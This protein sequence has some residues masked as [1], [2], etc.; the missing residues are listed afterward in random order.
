VP[1]SADPL[2]DL[3]ASGRVRPP[4]IEPAEYPWLRTDELDGI[5]VS[6]ELVKMRED[7]RF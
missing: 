1:R 7:E 6:D 3:I 5:N 4:T 2:D